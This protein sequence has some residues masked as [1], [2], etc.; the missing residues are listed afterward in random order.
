MRIIYSQINSVV[1]IRYYLL[2]RSVEKHEYDQLF[3]KNKWLYRYYIEILIR[4]WIVNVDKLLSLLITKII[5][6]S[7]LY[8]F[9]FE[10]GIYACMI[11]TEHEFVLRIPLI[12]ET[13]Y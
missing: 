9:I 10:T 12:Y 7:L 1:G 13:H 5:R 6:T 3:K 11:H 4:L 8:R 2:Y